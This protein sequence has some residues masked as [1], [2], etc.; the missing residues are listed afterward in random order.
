[1]SSCDSIDDCV[2]GKVCDAGGDCIDPPADPPPPE[3]CAVQ[4]AGRQGRGTAG[5]AIALALAALA[6][7]RR[8][9]PSTSGRPGRKE[10][11]R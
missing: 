2:D 4:G 6:T 10:A 5:L 7:R 8:R 11:S 1:L 9:D 3:D